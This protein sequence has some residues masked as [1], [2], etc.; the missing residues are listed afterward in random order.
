MQKAASSKKDSKLSQKGATDERPFGPFW[1]L[2]AQIWDESAQC[3]LNSPYKYHSKCHAEKPSRHFSLN[4]E[5]PCE[6]QR[7]S[8]TTKK[9]W[10]VNLKNI[11]I[12]LI[13]K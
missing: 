8:T 4:I 12:G 3:Y 1:V 11:F 13:F 2:T 7:I 6:R 10:Q 5:F 9:S